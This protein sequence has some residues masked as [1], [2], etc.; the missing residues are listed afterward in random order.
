MNNLQNR[1][2]AVMA[3][4]ISAL[5]CLLGAIALSSLLI[6][7]SPSGTVSLDSLV[8]LTGRYDKFWYDYKTRDNEFAD[9]LIRIDADLSSLFHWNTKQ[10][11]VYV[12]AEYTSPTHPKN[13]I[14]LWDAIIKKKSDAVLRKKNIP[15]K[16]SVIDVNKKWQNIH[17][18][19]SLHWNVVPYVGFMAFGRSQASEAYAF[20]SP[21]SSLP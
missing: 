2:N 9:A 3:F 4:S 6:P 10:L 15:N 8:V 19:V 11:F 13:Q 20:P 7:A 17:A 12:V 14:V 21:S 1:A 5:F 18:N 16:Y